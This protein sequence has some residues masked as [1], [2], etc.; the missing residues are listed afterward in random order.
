[1]ECSGWIASS[2][3]F[4]LNLFASSLFMSWFMS[5]CPSG[6]SQLSKLVSASP[7]NPTLCAGANI[8]IFFR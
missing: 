8:K 5:I 2:L 1:M 6:V 3:K 4:A 7:E